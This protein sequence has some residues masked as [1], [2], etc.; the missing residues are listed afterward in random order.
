MISEQ[1]GI[2]K[3]LIVDDL[4]N[5]LIALEGLLQRDDVEIFKALSGT[6]AL[7]YMVN[8]DFA[9]ALIDVKMPVMS[10]FELAELMRGTNRTKNIP[11][12]FGG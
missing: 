12:I 3:I 6:E 4:I 2:F 1:K 10:G 5:N 9:L 8:H 11:I 7:E